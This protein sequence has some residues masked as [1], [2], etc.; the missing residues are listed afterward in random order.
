MNGELHA[1]CSELDLCLWIGDH[2]VEELADFC[3]C[4]FGCFCLFRGNFTKSWEDRVVNC[5]YVV[6]KCAIHLLD[7]VDFFVW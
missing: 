5:N 7:E 1:T 4:I 3:H 6:Y 2:V